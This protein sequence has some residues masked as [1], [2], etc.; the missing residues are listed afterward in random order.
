MQANLL[1]KLH[2]YIYAN[3]GL[4]RQEAFDEIVKILLIKIFDEKEKL[5]HFFVIEKEEIESGTFKKRLTELQ[6]YAGSEKVNLSTPTL[7]YTVKLL[8]K[9]TLKSNKNLAGE[10]FQNFIADNQKAERGQFF[11]PR[12][13]VELAVSMVDP[14]SDEI[15]LDPACGGGGFLIETI[16]YLGDSFIKK[17]IRGVEINPRV[18]QI[19][20]LG[21]NLAGG[22]ES[23]IVIA[24]S[25]LESDQN[26]ADVILANPPFGVKG[27]VRERLVL[28]KYS[29]A[30]NNKSMVP[31]ILFIERSFNLLKNG[32]RM[33]I[34]LPQGVLNNTN[35]E[36][37]R[38]YLLDKARILAVVGLHGNTFRPHAGVKTSLLFL[39]KPEENKG[40][41]ERKRK[42][43]H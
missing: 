1:G 19:A 39:Q 27:R 23:K 40:G 42:F 12:E 4:G 11:T 30:E 38:D 7:I 13:I 35:M 14:K 26:V 34:V 22:D 31:E 20:K 33:A 21:I 6:K 41:F 29:L 24:N 3:E 25:L 37:V 16:S 2:N 43:C 32:G 5:N 36:Y 10:V 9:L 18:A 15:V 8:Q 28:N 17:N